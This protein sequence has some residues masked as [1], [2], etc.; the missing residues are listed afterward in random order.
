MALSI[1]TLQNNGL[2]ATIII[3]HLRREPLF[4]LIKSLSMTEKSYFRK[5]S[6]SFAG[7][8]SQYLLLF[9]EIQAMDVYD[10]QK[11]KSKIGEKH[12]AQYK[13][14]L[15]SKILESLR[16]YHS[17][18]SVEA[19]ISARIQEYNILKAKGLNQDAQKALLKAQ[20]L[21][22]SNQRMADAMK[23][24][25]YEGELVKESNDVGQLDRHFLKYL[26]SAQHIHGIIRQ[27][28]EL[29]KV[30][31]EIVK[32]HKTLEWVRTDREKL[33]LERIVKGSVQV[34]VIQENKEAESQRQYIHGLRYYFL[35]EFEKSYQSFNRQLTLYEADLSLREDEL[36]FVRCL[37]NNALLSLFTGNEDYN[38]HYLFL[39]DL[40]L[41]NVSASHYQ[42]VLNILLMTIDLCKKKKYKQ[43]CNWIKQYVTEIASFDQEVV[44]LN[45]SYNEFTLM[46]FYRV[47]AFLGNGEP[48]EALKAINNYLN[49]AQKSLKKDTYALAR[50]INLLVHIELE[51]YDLLEYELNTT[52][53]H[54]KTKSYIRPFEQKSVAFVRSM[55]KE[56]SKASKLVHLKSY[57][58][59]LKELK[60]SK[61]EHVIFQFF[62]FIHWAKSSLENK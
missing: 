42:S 44:D 11:L 21:A 28:I 4:E 13:K 19:K 33:E 24:G 62:D 16:Q 52:E 31:V 49:N 20:K 32:W 61:Y 18:H 41:K 14:H 47:N 27:Q 26:E 34:Q 39:N 38:E 3:F 60:E 29:E 50:I 2:I 59:A 56:N 45:T 17:E 53:Q 9:D 7:G 8:Q 30:H 12:F 6:K 1:F 40:K 43:A 54:L 51:N 46:S 48:K 15:H 25:K 55:L 22:I 35:G 5:R 10:E 23:I 57:R 58:N 37:G 36:N